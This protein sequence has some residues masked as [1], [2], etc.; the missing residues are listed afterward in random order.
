MYY[1][2][3]WLYNVELVYPNLSVVD[4]GGHMGSAEDAGTVTA[5]PAQA[6]GA[7]AQAQGLGAAAASREGWGTAEATEMITNNLFYITVKVRVLWTVLP[8]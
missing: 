7:S 3:P 2:L 1:L 5:A 4:G 8:G 6:K